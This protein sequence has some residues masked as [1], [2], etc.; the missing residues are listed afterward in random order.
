M[1]ADAAIVWANRQLEPVPTLTFQ[2]ELLLL[3]TP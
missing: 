1:V 3:D 2:L